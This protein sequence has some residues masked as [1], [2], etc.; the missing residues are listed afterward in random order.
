MKSFHW[1]L[2]K[3]GDGSLL[4][5]M[6]KYPLDV[7]FQYFLVAQEK[8]FITITQWYKEMTVN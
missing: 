1:F 6:I 2:T 7:M 8:V 4:L 3:L 5:G